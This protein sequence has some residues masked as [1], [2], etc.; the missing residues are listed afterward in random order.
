MEE[1]F[2][3]PSSAMRKT[4]KLYAK[5]LDNKDRKA[6]LK[7][8]GH[9]YQTPL[10]LHIDIMAVLCGI[11]G[12]SAQDVII[13]VMSAGLEKKSNVALINIEKFGNIEAFW[14]DSEIYGLS[15]SDDRPLSNLR[16]ILITALSQTMPASA[17]RGTVCVRF[18]QGVL[19]SACA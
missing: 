17:L 8:I 15:N 13:A 2:V 9:T 14:V 19:L 16:H 12:G 6:K 4:M 3:E 1:L 10:Q 7:R 11:N 5:F 18:Q